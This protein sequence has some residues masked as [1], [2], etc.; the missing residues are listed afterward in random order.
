ME[1]RR[2][3]L[4]G[5]A[6]TAFPEPTNLRASCTP[7]A[8]ASA[9]AA[10]EALE[11]STDELVTRITGGRASGSPLAELVSCARA[12]APELAA[13]FHLRDKGAER[14][15]AAFELARRLA[16]ARLPARPRIGGP[17]DVLALLAPVVAG[18]ERENFFV[19]LLDGRHRVRARELVSVG[20]LNSSLVHPR[21]VFR[22]A[23]RAAAAAI[24]CAH[25]HPS[26]DPTPSAEDIAVTKRLRQSG[27]LLGIPLLDHVVIGDGN[28]HSLRECEDW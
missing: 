21:E 23:I 8:R 9:P 4:D 17:A 10:V 3:S 7:R 2:L 5:A 13:R 14:L 27:E 22:P 15:A 18:E 25:N 26:G 24:V 1:V 19:L 16:Y 28:W 12:S 11:A 6:P 20:T